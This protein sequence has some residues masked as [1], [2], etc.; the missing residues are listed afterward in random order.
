[1]MLRVQC[2]LD[3]WVY[4]HRSMGNDEYS[5][6]NLSNRRET[7]LLSFEGI[8]NVAGGIC[9]GGFSNLLFAGHLHSMV[10]RLDL[11]F[12]SSAGER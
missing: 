10:S 3:I 6:Y 7:E 12:S 1:M 4:L 2:V 11:H 5:A 8:S 9:V